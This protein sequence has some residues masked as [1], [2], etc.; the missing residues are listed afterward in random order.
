MDLTRKRKLRS[1]T[2]TESDQ[3][4]V[5]L[6]QDPDKFVALLPGRRGMRM[7]LT[8][9]VTFNDGEDGC[10]MID[11]KIPLPYDYA[12]ASN[13]SSVADSKDIQ[14]KG[15]FKASFALCHICPWKEY[16]LKE[17]SKVSEVS[18]PSEVHQCLI[19]SAFYVNP[20]SKNISLTSADNEILSGIGKL[21]LC[22]GINYF[23]QNGYLDIENTLVVLEADGGTTGG[24]ANAQRIR[25]LTEHGEEYVD[26]LF[27]QNF[28]QAI[29]REG[30]H[31]D[32]YKLERKTRLYVQWE[33]NKHL[34]NYYIRTFGFQIVAKGKATGVLMATPLTTFMEHCKL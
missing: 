8:G 21:A 20:K 13:F 18:L 11:L 27:E 6:T 15:L 33:N 23:Q 24:K 2:S 30:R 28:S 9:R 25:E 19:L 10:K 17:K 5:Y 32:R 4:I 1:S 14:K 16:F 3:D 31:L 7:E 26:N 34:I 22:I 12:S 29:N